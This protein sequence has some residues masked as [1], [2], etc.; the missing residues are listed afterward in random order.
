MI[1]KNLS[2][3]VI[4]CEKDSLFID[5][6]FNYK[7]KKVLSYIDS[8]YYTIGTTNDTMSG[9]TYKPFIDL[10][11]SFSFSS[12]L[13]DTPYCP[14][15]I[16]TPF[17]IGS[18]KNA[19]YDLHLFV[20][21]CYD[22]FISS[23]TPTNETPFIQVQLRSTYL[24]LEGV[25]KAINESRNAVYNILDIFGFNVEDELYCRINRV[26]YCYHT[27]YI[28]SPYKFFMPD[29]IARMQCSRFKDSSM[30][31]DYIDG[32]RY[33]IDYYSFGNRGNPVFLR[34][35]LKSKEV[36]E[37]G[38][39]NKKCFF[40]SVWRQ[41]GLISRYDAYLLTHA[42]IHSNWNYVDYARLEYYIEFGDN[43]MYKQDARKLLNQDT[44]DW[45]KIRFLANLLTPP[46]HLVCNVEFQCLRKFFKTCQLP[47]LAPDE[48]LNTYRCT[49]I[50]TEYLTEHVF[51]FVDFNPEQD[52]SK[53]KY[54][55]EPIPF[56]K[57]IQ[58][59]HFKPCFNGVDYK[60]VRE[61]SSVTN[62]EMLKNRAYSSISTLSL[63]V[64]GDNYDSLIS[65]IE[66]L[67]AITNDND[68]A[69]Q[70]QKKNQKKSRVSELDNKLKP[71][72]K[73]VRL[74][75]LDSGEIL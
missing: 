20:T 64:N 11:S 50:I 46:L 32:H 2:N 65:D 48:L 5:R 36:V 51:K 68:I 74:L 72:R 69:T 53:N 31:V 17:F 54:R 66:T 41:E 10:I 59:K 62:L 3:Y 28:H 19:C 22:V 42:Y 71:N 1:D 27:N 56:W 12:P 21:D 47:E 29:N 55:C 63:C 45:S 40:I 16:D 67:A 57:L 35:Y 14:Q 39:K 13:S 34:M 9:S 60:L 6:E 18:L 58:K 30:H 38:Y 33:Q 43:D 7:D 75:N 8:F 70:L 23:A 73:N 15:W 25:E 37:C 52:T 26:D 49:D 61:Y 44:K 4:C 24:W